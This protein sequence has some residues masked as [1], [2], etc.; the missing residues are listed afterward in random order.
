MESTERKTQDWYND[1]YQKKGKD[2]NDL[3]TN[4]EVLFQHLAFEDSVMSALRR[5]INLDRDS[6]RVLDVGCGSGGSLTRFLQLG[7]VPANLYGIDIIKERVEEGRK[8]FPNLNLICD[9]ATS[10]SF[11]S[12]TF[13]LVMESTMF[14]QITDEEL[15]QKIAEEMLRVTKPGGYL[16]LIDWRYGKPR[17]PNYL[18]VSMK[19]IN[20]MFSVG[21]LSD[22][23]CQTSGALVPPIGRAISKYIPSAY[24]LLRAMVPFLVG[25]KTTLLQKRNL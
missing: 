1:Y 23:V 4:P 22:V 13:D 7:F 9:D 20:K 12:N 11:E 14:I 6:H 5:A 2:R 17:N 25:C 15:S 18:A 16:M 21:S 10:M 8:K 3:L 19:R 24:F